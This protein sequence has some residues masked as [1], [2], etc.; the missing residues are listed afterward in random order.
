MSAGLTRTV[1]MPRAKTPLKSDLLRMELADRLAVPVADILTRDQAAKLL[2][3]HPKTLSNDGLKA[4]CFYKGD[5]GRNGVALYV[6]EQ[7]SQWRDDPVKRREMDK[8]GKG[9]RPLA[10]PPPPK[11]TAG[12]RFLDD[13][14]VKP[15]YKKE[16]LGR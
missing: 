4:P 2:G 14:K 8:L 12:E 3:K 7:L 11:N 16:V 6:R 15:E 10:W 1:L 9:G 13:L 5:L